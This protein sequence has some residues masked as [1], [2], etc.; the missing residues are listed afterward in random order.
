MKTCFHRF[1]S[2]YLQG[3]CKSPG[4]SFGSTEDSEISIHRAIFSLF[5]G[6]RRIGLEKRVVSVFEG[7]LLALCLCEM[8]LYSAVSGEELRQAA[9]A[10]SQWTLDIAQTRGTIY[11]CR[12]HPLTGGKSK[13]VAAV[14][15][16]ME[17]LSALN[18]MF[19]ASEMKDIRELFDAGRPFLLE[20]PQKIEA[21]GMDV[22]QISG[23]YQENPLAV[24][25]LGYVNSEG[26]GMAGAELA[27]D[28]YLKANQG[29]ISVTYQVDALQRQL[30][31]EDRTVT[32]TAYKGTAGV[33]LTLDE[34]IQEIAEAAASKY[35]DKGAVV[36]GEIP[37]CSL[38]AVVS[39]PGF[40]QENPSASMEDPD[41][42]FLNRA[43]N[44][45]SVGS[46]FKLV[47]ATAALEYG[48]SPDTQYACM[49]AIPVSSSYFHC[50]NGQSH[51]TETMKEAIANSCNTYFVNLMQ[52]VPQ[53]RFLETARSLGF[54][55]ELE[56]MPGCISAAGV[57]PSM[58]TLQYP[59]GLAN[60]SFGQGELTAT[61][62]QI[63]AMVNAI[64]SG[65]IY[66]EPRLYEGIVDDTQEFL[67]RAA[68]T[69]KRRVMSEETASFLQSCMIASAEDGTSSRGN[70]EE[71]GGAG[72]KTATAQ[73][74][75]YG[76]DGEEIVQCWYVGFWPK[77]NP[78]YVITV[79][80]EDGEGG[81]AT[82]G[83]VFQ[84]IAEELYALSGVE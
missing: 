1:Y 80:E 10:Q 84:E 20:V 64:A 26:D 46:V 40:S 19:T 52:G 35:L 73:T 56:L 27:Y 83:P 77:E 15:P 25:V 11:D 13:Y 43:F 68:L 34:K 9:Q 28:Q 62:V 39:V 74:G 61:P 2:F 41:S 54:G 53:S 51:G 23:R 75:R 48:I 60:A 21:E 70:P 36:I 8:N 81:G 3:K 78:H 76:E 18:R 32:N 14:A 29:E 57:L 72:A 31:G 42:P 59:K 17:S 38:R 67:E 50:F 79:F 55:E 63:T 12:L 66:A 16:G 44:A 65:G 82:C 71:A 45:Y 4:G 5:C 22:F 47:S 6:E 33:V 24:H 58:K 7:I 37:S 30:E 69:E 49:G